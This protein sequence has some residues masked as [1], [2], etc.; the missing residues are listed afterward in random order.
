MEEVS[1]HCLS[2]HVGGQGW[3]AA[4]LAEMLNGTERVACATARHAG[5]RTTSIDSPPHSPIAPHV[6]T[7]E[8]L[9]QAA[10]AAA[11]AS[12]PT[13][14]YCKRISFGEMIACEHPECLIEWFHF[15]CVGLTA[16]NRPK[17]KWYCKECRKLMGKK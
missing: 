6:M 16:E 1:L 10:L 12:E 2:G 4:G 11:D 15:E 3:G 14:C 9:Y 7:S 17:G 5:C 13:Y 8:E